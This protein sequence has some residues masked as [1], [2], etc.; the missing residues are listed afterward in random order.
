MN[1]GVLF[2]FDEKKPLINDQTA[3]SSRIIADDQSVFTDFHNNVP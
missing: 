1:S 3:N 2:N